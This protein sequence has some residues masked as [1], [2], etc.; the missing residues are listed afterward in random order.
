MLKSEH[1]AGTVSIVYCLFQVGLI[2]FASWRKIISYTTHNNARGTWEFH[3][4]VQV[5]TSKTWQASSWISNLYTWMGFPRPSNN[6]VIDSIFH[7]IHVQRISDSLFCTSSTCNS[8]TLLYLLSPSVCRSGRRS[9]CL[10]SDGPP[11]NWKYKMQLLQ[12]WQ[13]TVFSWL[14]GDSQIIVPR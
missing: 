14:C 9:N 5:A 6:M 2:H 11:E 1:L 4:C 3:P 12:H 10:S 13:Y 7:I 8:A